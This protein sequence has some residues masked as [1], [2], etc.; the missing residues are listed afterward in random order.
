MAITE[1]LSWAQIAERLTLLMHELPPSWSYHMKDTCVA[2]QLRLR[3]IADWTGIE[4]KHL[5]F[6][7]RGERAVLVNR[8]DNQ[9]KLSLFF[10]LW[11][12][13]KLV[14]GKDADGRWRIHHTQPQV[15][16]HEAHAGAAGLSAQISWADGTLKVKPP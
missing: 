12:A 8:P 5:Y 11:D 7:R 15:P 1:A 13:H 2:S 10:E 6:M 3:D 9:R 16:A 4:R 14:K